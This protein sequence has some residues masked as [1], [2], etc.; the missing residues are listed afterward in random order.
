MLWFLWEIQA[1][2]MFVTYELGWEV[3]FR[4]KDWGR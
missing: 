1:K 2:R 3:C 4:T